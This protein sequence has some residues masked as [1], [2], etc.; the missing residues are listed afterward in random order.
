[1]T[2]EWKEELP[3]VLAMVKGFQLQQ[4]HWL[5]Q[6]AFLIKFGPPV[7]LHSKSQKEESIPLLQQAQH[8]GEVIP[9]HRDAVVVT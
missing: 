8:Q 6:D 4:E 2:E 1:M 3:L 9:L 5:T 7:M